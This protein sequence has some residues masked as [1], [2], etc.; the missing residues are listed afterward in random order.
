MTI[1]H[2]TTYLIGAA[3]A[4]LLS[5]SVGNAQTTGHD[6][7]AA[8]AP[9]DT[10]PQAQ[11]AANQHAMMANMQAAQKKLDDLVAQMN[12]AAGSEKVDRMAAVITEMAAMHKDMCAQ[13]MN[14]GMMSMMMM[15]MQHGAASQAAPGAESP[16]ADHAGHHDPN[17]R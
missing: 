16:D 12:A 13:M 7:S 3:A 17:V 11:A 4:L 15:Q 1:K 8:P 9:G 2:L 6:H 14:G 5:A 10:S